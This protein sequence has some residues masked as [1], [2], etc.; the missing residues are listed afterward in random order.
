MLRE[1][2]VVW[3][4]TLV[5][6]ARLSQQWPEACLSYTL[7]VVDSTLVGVLISVL[8]PLMASGESIY[9]WFCSADMAVKTTCADIVGVSPCWLCLA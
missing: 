8:A 7:R 9:G 2:N 1:T 3:S 6:G 4:S 5:C